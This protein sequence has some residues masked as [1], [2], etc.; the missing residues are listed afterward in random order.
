MLCYS[1]SLDQGR[2]P[3]HLSMVRWG[4]LWSKNYLDKVAYCK[5][6]SQCC[7]DLFTAQFIKKLNIIPKLKNITLHTFISTACFFSLILVWCTFWPPHF[8]TWGSNTIVPSV[9]SEGEQLVISLC[10]WKTNVVHHFFPC[11]KQLV[12]LSGSY[13]Y[14]WVIKSS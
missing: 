14:D 4:L 9:L 7:D 12:W 5:E 2:L 11:V 13:I 10:N 8:L 3:Q 1:M 6:R